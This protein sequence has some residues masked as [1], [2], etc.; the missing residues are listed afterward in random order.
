MD[1]DSRLE[2]EMP[3]ARWRQLTAPTVLA[4]AA[5]LTLAAPAG[6]ATA[7]Q[8][9]GTQTVVDETAGTYKMHGSLVGDWSFTSYTEIATSPIYRAKGTELF[10]GCLD[11]RRDGSCKGD[12]SGTLQ[13][14]FKYWA[15]FDAQGGLVWGTCTHPIT[16][17]TGAFAGATGVLAMVDTPT[18]Q[19]VSTSYIGNVTLR[20]SNKSRAHAR[21]S[22]RY[23]APSVC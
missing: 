11:V 20:G 15:Q 22:A 8:V 16:G 5:A 9:S 13:F 23:A 6:A 18:P 14:K 3:K 1:R 2:A 19:G 10:S 21:T 17:G 7:Y 4:V 12:P